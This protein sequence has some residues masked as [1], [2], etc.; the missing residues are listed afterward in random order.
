MNFLKIISFVLIGVVV[1]LIAT[2]YL[3]N[4][5]FQDVKSDASDKIDTTIDDVKDN[6]LFSKPKDAYDSIKNKISYGSFD[7]NIEVDAYFCPED[8]CLKKLLELI[9]SSK[10]TIDCAVYDVSLE[11]VSDALIARADQGIDVRFVSDFS[12]SKNKNSSIGLLKDSNVSV[13]TNSTESSYMHNKFCV[14]DEKT[15]FVGSMNFT[16]NGNYKNNN[17]VLIVK[18]KEIAKEYTSKINSFFN[19]KFSPKP[20]EEYTV[21]SYGN[22]ENYFCPEDDCLYNLLR[23]VDDT[24]YSLDCMLFSFT[25]DDFFQEIVDKNIDQR[26]ILESR[27]NSDY[28]KYQ[29]LKNNSIP[30]ILD[31]NPNSMH[32]KFCIVDDYMVLTGSMN[33]SKNGTENND[34]SFL[35]V[36]DGNLAKEY[37]DYFNSYWE[38]WGNN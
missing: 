18:D 7:R 35:V 14:F 31:K 33:Y 17:N 8:D 10:K 11:S 34:E 3:A 16:L 24:N 30:V 20:K 27:T 37:K 28:S 6:N 38:L 5:S 23:L 9:N 22:L 4:D 1:F 19:G 36:Y 2:S 25:L 21:N 29:D 12:A 32:N 15:V 13:I 26:Y